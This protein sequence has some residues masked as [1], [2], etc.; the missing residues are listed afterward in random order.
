VTRKH[1]AS[2]VDRSLAVK[3]F[4]KAARFKADAEKMSVL[5]DEFSGNG[6]AVLC[7]HAAISVL[8]GGRKSKSGDHR[9]AAPFLA[10]VIPIRT[11]EDK[12]ALRAFQTILNRKDAVSY[13]DDIV[14][15][16]EVAAL[17]ERLR[18]FSRWAEKTFADLRQRA[19]AH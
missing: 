15:D 9:D 11:V 17:L 18:A 16:A 5:A 19:P 14:D 1:P 4:D 6:V 7:V 12:A 3:Y 2:T 10:S 13:L 8:A